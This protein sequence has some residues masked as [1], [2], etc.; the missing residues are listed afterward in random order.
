ML[1]GVM[2]AIATIKRG[3]RKL[4]E[5]MGNEYVYYFDIFT[6]IH[7]YKLIKLYTLFKCGLP[8]QCYRLCPVPLWAFQSGLILV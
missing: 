3:T 6:C 4:L 2:P 7:I 8:E 5:V 1:S